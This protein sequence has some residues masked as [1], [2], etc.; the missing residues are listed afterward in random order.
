MA[1]VPDD[2][3]TDGKRAVRAA[4]VIGE[5]AGQGQPFFFAVGFSKPHLPFVAPKKYWDL[6]QR[7]DFTM[8]PNKG[9]PPGYPPYAANLSAGELRQYADINDRVPTEFPDDLNARL[10]HGYA[11]C[12]SYADANVGILLDAL[13]KH[14][15]EENTIVVVWGDHG[16]KLGDHSTWCKH[17]NFECDTRAPLL[18]RVP[19]SEAG[20][21]CQ[22][23]VEF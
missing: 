17:T 5:L 8:P 1:D 22:R 4:Q 2:T 21:V 18:M 20:Q 7:E 14:G 11:A 10:L 16:W 15:L 13:E 23:L 3:Y 9:I 12:T 19:G 6:Y